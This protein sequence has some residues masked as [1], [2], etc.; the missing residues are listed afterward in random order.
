MSVK[1]KLIEE[2]TSLVQQR[3]ASIDVELKKIQ[4]DANSET[5]SSMGDK[6]ETG[7]AMAQNEKSKLNQN[8][9][10]FVNHLQTINKLKFSKSKTVEFGSVVETNQL[11]IFLS[12]ALGE[13]TIDNKK[14]FCISPL[15]PL[16]QIL[17]DKTI[18]NTFDFNKQNW[19]ILNVEN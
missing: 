14:Y 17:K 7:R 11:N 9:S 12:T 10:Q 3:L 1:E 6:Y 18:G 13:L 8:K 16:G 4:D 2:A 15:T 5:K 19:E